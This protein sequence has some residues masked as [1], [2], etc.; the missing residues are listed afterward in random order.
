[1]RKH[2]HQKRT[3]RICLWMSTALF[4]FCGAALFLPPGAEAST[5]TVGSSGC[6]HTTLEAAI[7]AAT[8]GDTIEIAAGT[9]TYNTGYTVDKNITIQGP[10]GG[11]VILQTSGTQGSVTNVTVITINAGITAT[12]KNLTIQNGKNAN[13]GGIYNCG[14]LTMTDCIIQNNIATSNGG[15]FFNNTNAN[16]EITGCTFSNNTATNHGGGMYHSGSSSKITNCT[17]SG[18]ETTT[19]TGGGI[20]NANEDSIP[21]ISNCTFSNNTAITNGGGIANLA[22]SSPTITNCTFS[23]N[24]TTT[25]G[26]NSGWGGGVHNWGGSPT[27][28]N[29]TFS[30][31]SAAKQGGGI[32][33]Y[34]GNNT[35]SPTIINCT[36]S[37]NTATDQGGGMYNNGSNPTVTNCIFWGTNSTTG[38]I[39]QGDGGNGTF[40][41]CVTDQSGEGNTTN[42]PKLKSLADNGGP[43]Q[44][45]ALERRSPALNAGT[46]TGAPATDQ[47]GIA[48][49]QGSG[50]D[51]GAVEMQTV[52]VNKNAGGTGDGS[53]WANACTSLQDGLTLANT[54]TTIARIWV[55]AGTYKPAANGGALD[56][57]FALLDGVDLY[58]GFPDTGTPAWTDRDPAANPTI[59]SGNLSDTPDEFDAANGGYQNGTG[60]DN[61]Y[62]VVTA[63]NIT[64]GV[65]LEGFTVTGGKAN[66][67]SLIINRAGGGIWSPTDGNSNITI[68]KCIVR[69]ND[70]D[71]AGGGIYSDTNNSM[72]VTDCSFI[73]N[74]GANVGGGMYNSKLT[75]GT[76]TNCT[77]TKNYSNTGGGMSNSLGNIDMVNCTFTEN[78]SN[79][80]GAGIRSSG[81]SSTP[82][83]LSLTNCTLQ[84]NQA[85]SMGG[86][87]HL[88]NTTLTLTNTI[89]WGNTA[90]TSDS[91]IS[92]SLTAT[93][94]IIQSGDSTAFPGTGN[95]FT[96]PF[97]GDLAD[98]GGITQTC[99]PAKNSSALGAG[100]PTSALTV[101]QRG[102]S[103]PQ[104]GGTNV[105]IGAVEMDQG[106]LTVTL[107]PDAAVTAGA[108]WGLDGGNTWHDSGATL[109]VVTGS[110]TVSFK[111]IPG[112]SAP[113]SKDVTV[114]SNTETTAT[115]TYTV[116]PPTPT[117]A[118]APAPTSAPVPVATTTPVPTTTSTPTSA[119]TATPVPGTPIPTISP[120]PISGDVDPDITITPFLNNH[121]ETVRTLKE[122]IE[123]PE[124]DIRKEMETT[125]REEARKALEERLGQGIELDDVT[126]N[127]HASDA[128]RLENAPLSEEG[129]TLVIPVDI[130]Y[131][132][133]EGDAVKLFFVMIMAYDISTTPPT[134]L[135]YE[136]VLLEENDTDILSNATGEIRLVRSA[137]NET[138]AFLQITDQSMYD[139][140][141]KAGVI[142]VEYVFLY[143]DATLK[144]TP[145]PTGSASGGGS[146]GGCSLGFFPLALLLAL[147]LML[148]KK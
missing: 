119:P 126:I 62:H 37:G 111:D 29:C 124:S 15:G 13:G 55:A 32:F 57:T 144:G 42:D 27:I 68:N 11:T 110:C 14:S 56:S 63:E 67:G 24:R 46:S 109:T 36:F 73:N 28:T 125:L 75:N 142:S 121:D 17:F 107:S 49:P 85:G 72:T 3:I 34:S 136:L 86:G 16:S 134:A 100:D 137:E 92:G 39:A 52:Y 79:S 18:N 97:L 127:I 87:I 6:N 108:K 131:Q 135:G 9:Y 69:D 82:A 128:Y 147:P 59:L 76:F 132:D 61:V 78:Q 102:E 70:A 23:E 12:L 88:D 26:I 140:N 20:C 80:S 53:S 44:T 123:N 115:E 25:S 8:G 47:R 96:D 51:M 65:I 118:P 41:Y 74:R 38:Q 129:G 50:Y 4:L 106:T 120:K 145:S 101:D 35:G 54:D 84:G 19:Y 22:N 30:G 133:P 98:N 71:A 7:D 10:A 31:N 122:A 43:T 130:T 148:L 99:K 94:C 116:A 58:G 105:D 141:R 138:E 45:C 21:E 103:R 113:A 48:R 117:S 66:N 60:A 139:A 89:L 1:M 91:Q 77:F 114:T 33:S 83:L 93:Y 90:E 112:Y 40:T 81:T 104:P 64:T 146:G 5:I 2:K 95:R 143:G